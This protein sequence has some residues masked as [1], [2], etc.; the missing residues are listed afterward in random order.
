MNAKPI[1]FSGSMVRALLAGTKTQTRR[2]VEPQPTECG[3]EWATACG[4]EFA[5]WQDPG[6]RLDEWSEDGGPCQRICP[7]GQAGDL[8]WVRETW[9]SVDD[10]EFDGGEWIDYRATPKYESSHPAGWDNEPGSPD[11]LKWRPSIHMPRSASR[12]TL[13]IADV[14]V[15]RLNEISNDDALAEGIGTPLDARY[16]A[17]DGFKSLW[18]SINGADSWVA[19]PWVW[20]IKF[21][22]IKQNIDEVLRETA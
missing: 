16:A 19:N 5:A 11:A 12:L 15:E 18:E 17:I 20:V 4:G 6:L 13:C 7:Y 2:I 10:S 21:T 8:L 9:C 1:L 14:R 3:L 22:V